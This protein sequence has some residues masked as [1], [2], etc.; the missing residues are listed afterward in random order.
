MPRQ[1][2]SRVHLHS[3]HQ[4][5]VG[6]QYNQVLRVRLLPNIE[7]LAT[8]F[9]MRTDA[10]ELH[11]EALRALVEALAASAVDA[12]VPS[13]QQGPDLV[14]EGPG[15]RVVV[16][17]KAVSVADPARVARLVEAN[18]KRRHESAVQ[19]I[20][21][22]VADEIP[23]ATRQLLRDK[24]WGYLDRRGRLWFSAA[25]IRINDTELTP[26]PRAGTL[27][28]PA[29]P[30]TGRAGLGVALQ[31]LMHPDRTAGVREL[32]RGSGCSPSSAHAAVA[33]LRDA[34][35]VE[36]DGRPLVPALFWAVAEVWHPVRY[37]VAREPSPGDIVMDD[38]AGG[39]W[40]VSGDV[41]AAAWGAPIAV[42][43]GSPPDL[44]APTPRALRQAVRRLGEA[45]WADRAATIASAGLAAV[46]AGREMQHQSLATPWLHW[47]LAH[48]VVV[49][50]DLAQDKSRGREIL[51][52]WGSPSGY[53]RVW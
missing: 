18:R 19:E 24:G 31:L 8:I 48:P 34:A 50:L 12:S 22:L 53:T 52:D 25:G 17:V 36:P 32:A 1:R 47:P 10:A 30:I 26:M 40:V 20:C 51:E 6:A 15:Q 9:S 37:P 5:H 44:Y 39:G 3:G 23:E 2:D 13:N 7:H 14:V 16:E 4:I 11:D 35:L 46:T 33:R 38:E 43:S 21:V 41:A 42:G 27:G 29:A 28:R 45:S 49:A